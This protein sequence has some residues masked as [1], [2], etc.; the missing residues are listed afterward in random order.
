MYII[1]EFPKGLDDS[2]MEIAFAVTI[3]VSLSLVSGVTDHFI[4]QSALLSLSLNLSP[5]LAESTGAYIIG[6]SAYQPR[7]EESSPSLWSQIWVG[8]TVPSLILLLLLIGIPTG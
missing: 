4:P 3:P 2:E 7:T 1:P 6:I 8:V 5:V